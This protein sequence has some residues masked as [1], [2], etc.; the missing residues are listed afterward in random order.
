MGRFD[1]VG[2]FASSGGTMASIATIRTWGEMIKFSH[3]VFA[4]P[5]AMIATFL[6]GRRLDGGL[7]TG[8]QFAL[9]ILCMVAARSFAMTFNRIADAAIDARNPRTAGRPIQT[10]RI[11]VAQASVFLVVSAAAFLAACSG[12]LVFCQNPWPLYL[13]GPT[14]IVLA[15]YSYAKRITALTHFILGATIAFAPMAAW[16]AIHPG[17]LGLSALLLTGI[18]LLWIAGF[19]IIYACQDMQVDRREGLYSIPAKI[20]VARAL[21]VSRICHAV[22]VAL[23]IWLGIEAEFG[24]LYWGAVIA[25]AL[26]FAAEQSVVRPDD[27]SKVNL[28]FFTING[29]ISL[30]LGVAAICDLLLGLAPRP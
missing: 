24:W 14:L 29:C 16:I 30:L 25:T 23:L 9:I 18:V 13:A 27:L 12:F 17:S 5:F 1:I 2:S 26:L 20:G 11:S 7:P 10:G 21:V 15:A 6:A 19:D 8:T 22:T 28:A 4:L 3:S